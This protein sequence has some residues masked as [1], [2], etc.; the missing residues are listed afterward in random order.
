MIAAH[1]CF[2]LLFVT[3]V[4]LNQAAWAAS[5]RSQGVLES[6]SSVSGSYSAP[7]SFVSTG[8]LPGEGSPS[9]AF[10]SKK[11]ALNVQESSPEEIEKLKDADLEAVEKY[12]GLG[13]VRLTRPEVAV[14]G[15]AVAEVSSVEE[16]KKPFQENLKLAQF[17]KKAAASEKAS[18]FSAREVEKLI[19]KVNEVVAG[20]RS[21]REG[22]SWDDPWTGKVERLEAKSEA[23][24]PC[25]QV[26]ETLYRGI[27]SVSW[28]KGA[29]FLELE[30]L[31]MLSRC[32][33]MP[34]PSVRGFIGVVKE[35]NLLEVRNKE[36]SLSFGSVESALIEA[37]LGHL[38]GFKGS[39]ETAIWPEG[40]RMP[41]SLTN[42]AYDCGGIQKCQPV[43][44][45]L[46]ARIPP[47]SKSSLEV[48]WNPTAAVCELA[49][50][51]DSLEPSKSEEV[52]PPEVLFRALRPPT[53]PSE[54]LDFQINVAK[55]KFKILVYAHLLRNFGLGQKET[56]SLCKALGPVSSGF[57]VS[58]AVFSK[59]IKDVGE[60]QKLLNAH[61]EDLQRMHKQVC[62]KD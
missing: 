48:A 34:L 46:H 41:P 30:A 39:L 37:L 1:L 52:P 42:A 60:K 43:K 49:A 51:V 55:E 53:G 20:Y 21:L 19:G 3:A 38:W 6:S 57:E 45:Y 4:L 33:L 8:R 56:K 12:L 17:L 32:E 25:G 23:E 47:K 15:R 61:K 11:E 2:K 58:S 59:K 16:M 36:L 13:C 28:A 62:G 5:A 27:A 44:D 9:S 22:G 18:A 40:V 24:N 54:Q 26:L 10:L 50:F 35:S 14:F 7:S 31:N 29:A